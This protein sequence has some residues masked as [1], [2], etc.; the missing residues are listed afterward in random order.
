MNTAVDPW[1]EHPTLTGR[2]IRL[3]PLEPAHAPGL[4]T[5]ADDDGVFRWMSWARPADLPA[6]RRMIDFYR[7]LPQTRAWA[8]IDAET[9]AVIGATACYELDST[10]RSL[11]I[12]YTWLTTRAHRTAAN[13]ESKLLLMTH[14]FDELGAV[15][16]TWYTDRENLRAQT[17]IQRLGARHE[18]VLRRHRKRRD[19]TWRDTMVYALLDH[20]WPTARDALIARLADR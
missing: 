9:G 14:A 13:T 15:R 10:H 16:V 18:G 4:L 7:G 20:E 2:S 12:G 17:A 6:A 3:D 8:Q 19:G 11:A 5:A 1:L